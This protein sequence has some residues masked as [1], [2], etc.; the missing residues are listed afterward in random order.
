MDGFLKMSPK[1][2]RLACLQVEERMHLQAASVEKD[3]WICWTLRELFALPGI[4]PHLTF[5]GGTSLSKAWKLIERFSEDIDLIVD[6]QTLGFAG[7]ASPDRAPSKKQRKLRLEALMEACRRWVQETL[8][9]ALA[10]R[11]R[12]A[13]GPTGWKLEVDPDMADGQ[14]LLFHYPGDFDPAEAGYVRPVVKIELGARSDDWPHQEKLIQPYLAEAFPNLASGAA[15]PVRVLAA[16]RTFWEKALLLHE[17]TFRPADKPRKFRMARHYYDVWCLI[18]RGV[19]ERAAQDRPLFDRVAA[20][21]EIF[22]RW[23]WVDYTT[24]HPGALRF[25]PPAH[26]LEAWRKDYQEMRGGMFFGEVPNFD[27]ILRVVGGFEKRFNQSS[28]A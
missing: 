17:E 2:R 6:K 18:T 8:Q 5:K 24:L 14:C 4:E 10:D 26:H 1:D 11:I 22:F 21:R 9:P 25:V 16:E 12:A 28:P 15:I 19:A 3:F 23:S 27:E 7:D 20:H 13:L